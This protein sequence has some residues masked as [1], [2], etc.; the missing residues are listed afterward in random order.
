MQKTIILQPLANKVIPDLV[1]YKLNSN[2]FN[3]KD[4]NVPIKDAS[5]NGVTT[6]TQSRISKEKCYD[7][8]VKS[9]YLF[10]PSITRSRKITFS[11]WINISAFGVGSRIFDYGDTFSLQIIDSK[12]IKFN[13][14][15]TVVYSTGLI[16]VWKH[17]AFTVAGTKLVFYENGVEI[18]A[19]SM[20]DTLSTTPTSGY[21]AH[22]FGPEV[23]LV[24][25]MSDFRIY[26]R[27]LKASEI[28]TL[29]IG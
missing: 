26:D 23:D 14:T 11:C 16:N 29:Y 18:L 25:K 6:Y 21:M 13:N 22:S 7:F 19:I 17:I 10:L 27:V 12:T 24:C 15:Y 8:T 5:S 2:I 4:T 9:N 1:W 20:V 3:Y 28:N